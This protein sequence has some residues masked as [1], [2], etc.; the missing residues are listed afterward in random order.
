MRR[1]L[2]L[3]VL[4]IAS[5]ATSQG[6]GS[7]DSVWVSGK[8]LK[9]GTTYTPPEG[10]RVTVTFVGVEAK[11]PSGKPIET[12]EPFTAEVN[13]AQGTFTVPGRERKGIPSG[14]YRVAVIQKFTREA[15]D[16]AYPKPPKKGIDRETDRL[17]NKYTL[18][19]SPIVREIR[20]SRDVVIDLDN[21]AKE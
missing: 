8:L 13:Q 4:L 10:E 15:F 5:L 20:S 19:N 12:G 16:K 6:C 3:I 18:Q 14:K 21:P 17:G 7:G 1:G 11:D 2:L 9:G